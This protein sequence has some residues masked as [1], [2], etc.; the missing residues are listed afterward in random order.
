[1]SPMM[2]EDRLMLM[3]RHQISRIRLNHTLIAWN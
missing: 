1:M 2:I 3:V